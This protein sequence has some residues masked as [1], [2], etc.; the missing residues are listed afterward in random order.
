MYKKN[1]LKLSDTLKTSSGLSWESPGNP[2][3]LRPNPIRFV[4]TPN[5][6]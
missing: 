1:T 2:N 5:Q 6:P 3:A 4:M